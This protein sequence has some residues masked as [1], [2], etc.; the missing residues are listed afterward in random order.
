MLG[1][2]KM[3]K[4]VEKQNSINDL[5]FGDY[6][7]ALKSGNIS[8]WVLEHKT[9]KGEFSLFKAKAILKRAFSEGEEI[10]VEKKY[11]VYFDVD[12]LVLGQFIA[13][14]TGFSNKSMDAADR[15]L[16]VALNIIR[17]ILDLHFDNENVEKEQR[18]RNDV[19]NEKSQYVLR[20]I[21]LFLKNRNEFLYEKYDGVFYV[22]KSEQEE[23][24]EEKEDE[25][26]NTFDVINSGSEWYWY[27]LLKTLSNNNI[28]DH[29]KSL[30]LPMPEVAMFVA[31]M[32]HEEKQQEYNRRVN[33]LKNKI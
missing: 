28:H 33:D 9:N 14:E 8:E 13:I 20:I 6:L 22:S 17:P 3:K 27:S 10:E 7:A 15:L 11:N 16:N 30:M 29:A 32:R 31:Y 21:E 2:L 26:K 5:T 19:L 25:E 23:E 1:V 24:K 12:S 4:K 18:H